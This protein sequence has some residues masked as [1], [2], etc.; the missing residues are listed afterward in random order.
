MF[1]YRLAFSIGILF[2]VSVAHAADPVANKLEEICREYQAVKLDNSEASIKTL[3]RLDQ[4]LRSLVKRPWGT[5]HKSINQE[6]WNNKKCETMGVYVGHYSEALEY[7][8]ALLWEV[9]KRDVAKQYE[10]YTSR[11]GV[12]DPASGEA[13]I[14]KTALEYEKR[15]PTGPFIED[16]L[17]IIGDFY[18]D[19]YLALKS[20]DQKDYKYEC[21]SPFFDKTP[22]PDQIERARQTAI[23]YYARVLALHPKSEALEHPIEEEKH[24]LEL[25]NDPG[26][27]FCAD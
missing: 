18:S 27:H 3:I 20:S 24:D 22:I 25:G 13:P 10:A 8:G 6:Y 1:I 7:S 15:F 2:V 19:L 17:I 12:P 5:V 23:K 16:T 21:Y 9:K 14:I 26:W 4:E 11:P